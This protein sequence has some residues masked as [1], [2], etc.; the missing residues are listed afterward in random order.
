[1]PS[2]SAEKCWKVVLSE[3]KSQIDIVCNLSISSPVTT[4][5]ISNGIQKGNGFQIDLSLVVNAGCPN[6]TKEKT[7]W[8]EE[9]PNKKNSVKFQIIFLQL[10]FV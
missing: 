8:I 5:R 4:Q 10:L 3:G 1:M 2:V 9:T 6:E 7:N